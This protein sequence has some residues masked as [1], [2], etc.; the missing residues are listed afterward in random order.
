MI[1]LRATAYGGQMEEAALLQCHWLIEYLQGL[2]VP[3]HPNV[4]KTHESLL[5]KLKVNEAFFVR[6]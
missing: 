6:W 3:V 2:R 1:K 4:V 5:A